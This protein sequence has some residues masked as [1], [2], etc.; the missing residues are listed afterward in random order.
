MLNVLCGSTS[1]LTND[2][3]YQRL[4]LI[5]SFEAATKEKEKRTSN[6]DSN[7]R[8][9]LEKEKKNFLTRFK[10]GF[11]HVFQLNKIVFRD[12]EHFIK[13]V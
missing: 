5:Q 11:K 1:D 10:K 7:G 12:L 2:T 3:F 8:N 13:N 4:P 9:K 6:I